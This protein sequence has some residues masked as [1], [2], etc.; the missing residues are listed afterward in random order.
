MAFGKVVILRGAQGNKMMNKVC[1]VYILQDSCNPLWCPRGEMMNGDVEL[2]PT[3]LPD[4][5]EPSW[6]PRR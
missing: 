4:S 6:S 3:N 5:Y 2:Q 1:S